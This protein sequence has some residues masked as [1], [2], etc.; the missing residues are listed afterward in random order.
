MDGYQLLAALVGSLAWPVSA[1]GI[2]FLLRR[3]IIALLGRARTAE[4]FGAKLTFGEE[5]S[6]AQDAISAETETAGIGQDPHPQVTIGEASR[7]P[8]TTDPAVVFPRASANADIVESITD[9][10]SKTSAEGSI[11]AAWSK[12][13]EEVKNAGARVGVRFLFGPSESAMKIIAKR[14]LLT[15]A[16][17]EAIGSLRK[18]RNDVVHARG[19]APTLED[20]QQYRATAESIRRSIATRLINLGSKPTPQALRAL[21]GDK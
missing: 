4:G 16:E 10:L 19:P 6:A 1:I 13:E 15:E 2:T 21:E 18:L 20:A 12:L 9:A 5:L 3:P 17:I 7:R 11:I 14:G 8:A